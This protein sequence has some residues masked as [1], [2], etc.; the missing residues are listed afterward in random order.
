MIGI[1]MYEEGIFIF[2]L[3]APF[4]AIFLNSS[5]ILRTLLFTGRTANCDY[6]LKNEN[7]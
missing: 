7:D 5:L 2:F 3:T 1:E 4:C 6:G